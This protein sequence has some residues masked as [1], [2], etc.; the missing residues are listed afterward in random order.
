LAGVQG[1][2]GLIGPAGLT[3]PAGPQ[4]PMG[5]AGPVG[6][7]GAQ[8]SPGPI[9][10]QG[11]PVANFIGNYLSTTNYGLHDAVSFGGSTYVSLIAGN[12][13]NTPDQSS[14]QWGGAGGTRSCGGG[15]ACGTC[16]DAGGNR[17]AGSAGACGSPRASGEFSGDVARG[18]SV[19]RG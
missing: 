4:G 19:C 16:R 3:G 1:P 5:A 9:G 7:A 12:V 14:A 10:P 11:P 17:C 6:A 13:G 2:Q 18:K 15:W 8:G